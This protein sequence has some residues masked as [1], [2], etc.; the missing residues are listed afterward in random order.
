MIPNVTL[1]Q[2]PNSIC[3]SSLTN[4]SVSFN[5]TATASITNLVGAIG[6]YTFTWRNGQLVTD[7]VNNTSTN[8]NLVNL[9][10]GYYTTTAVQTST[11]CTSTP[12]SVEVQNTSLLPV[13]STTAIGS[14]NCAAP[15]ANGQ[16]LVTDVNGA[17][18]ALPFV[19]KWHTGV[20]TTTPIVGATGATL[21][22]RQG[23][24]GAFFTVLVTNQ[25][26]GCQNTATV[27]VPDNQSIP[28][29]TVSATDNENCSAPF[30]GTASV[31][32][33]IYKGL[34][35]GLGGYSF[36]W[37]HGATSSSAS[38][39]NVGTYELTVT[40]VDV[41][42]TS[43]PVQVDVNNNIY[44]PLINIAVTNQ[45]SCDVLNPNGGLS[46]S[47]SETIIGGA[48]TETAGYTY[49]WTNDGNPLALG[50]PP[51][52]NTSSINTLPGNLFY[53]L[54]V[55]RTAT[56]CPNTQSVFLPERILLP[57]LEIVA[58]DIV[59]CNTNGFVTARIFVDKNGDGDSNDAGDELTPI[60]I[61]GDYSISWF[62]GSSAIGTP[63]SETDR[64]I[65]EL[66]P[67]VSLP[68]GNY[69][70]I[71]TNV[72]TSCQ[73][74]DFTDVIN[75][76][77][78]LFDIAVTINNRP[79]SCA[80][81]DG[82]MTA[83]VDSGGGV[84][85]PFGNFTFQ[86]FKGNPTNGLDVPTPSFYTDPVVQFVQP[87][88][89]V[90]PAG[91]FVNP[92]P[93]FPAPQAPT[94]VNTGPSLFGQ[95]SGTY[96]V[97][98]KNNTT[99]CKEF[100]TVF[101]PFLQEPVIILARIK[102][103]ECSGD[104]GEIEVELNSP[105]PANQYQLQIYAS[106]NPVFSGPF[107]TLPAKP[108]IDP[109]SVLGNKFTGLASGIYSVVARENPLLIPTGCYSSP[110]L[111]QLIEALPPKVDI[112]GSTDNSTCAAAPLVGDGSLQI[113]V[114]TDSNDPFSASYPLPLPPTILQQG[115]APFVTYSVD[116]KDAGN[117]AVPG[118][119]TGSTLIDGDTENI[120]GL[121]G[122][123][124]SITVTSS[125]GCS[126]T[127]TFEIPN[128][129]R[130]ADLSGD[131][132]VL[133]ALAC[134]PSLETNASVIVN[135]LSIPGVTAADNLS[136]YEFKW[137][138]DVSLTTNILTANGDNTA[139]KGGEVLSNV[140][141]PLP[142]APV[143][144]GSY[145]VRASKI[146]SGTTGGLGCLTAP[147]KVDVDDQSVKPT[148]VL[149]ST[150]DT[151]C[152][153]VASFEGSVSV[154]VTDAGSIPTPDYSYIWTSTGVSVI[155]ND[156]L[157]NGSLI[158]NPGLSNGTY[159]LSFKNNT[160]GCVGTIQTTI[161]KS[162]TPIV[163]SDATPTDQFICNP[164]GSIT[165]G[166]NDILVNGIVDNNHNR[167][168]FTWSRGNA[169]NVVVGP[170]QSEDVLD[171]SNL[172]TI[173]AD[174]YFVKV[175]KRS[176]LIPGS[177]CESAPFRVDI[178]D[179]S[180]DPTIRLTS[181][182]NTSCDPLFFE[183][184]LQVQ[185]TNPG[186]AASPNYDYTWTSPVATPIVNA[187][188]VGNGSD[189]NDNIANL[190]DGTYTVIVENNASG[191]F[192]NAQT[193][194]SKQAT[195]IVIVNA[196]P[197]DQFICNPDGSIVVGANDILVA[198]AV[199]S[200]HSHFDFTWS[201]SNVAAIVVGPT[202]S[203]DVLDISNLPTIGA[204]SYFVKVKKRSG[205][206]PGSGCES[207]PF[208]V[209]ILD[210]SVDPTI[211]LTSSPNTS[212]DPLFFEGS[213]QV[214]VTNP[215]SAAS[216][217]YDYTWTSPVATPIVNAT[218]VG[219]GSDPNDNI[220]N[221]SDGTYTVIVEN[222]A[223]G[224]FGTAQTIISKQTTPI[225][226]V[227]VTVAPQLICNPDGSITVND[228]SV[229][230]IV[231]ADHT[232]FD[233][234][235]ARGNVATTVVG[236]SQSEDVLDILNLST[237]GADSY[238]VKVKRR[239]G[240]S[241]GSGCESTPFKVEILDESKDPEIAFTSTV[242]NSSCTPSSPNGF[243]QATASERIGPSGAY[244]FVW[245]FNG[246]AVPPVTTLG[247]ASPISELTNAGPGS[248]AVEATNSGTGCKFNQ[249][250]VL[251]T[252]QT[253]SLPNI[254]DIDQVNPTNCLPQGSVKVVSVTI[255]GTTVFTDP[256]DDLDTDYNY[257]W[258]KNS[259][260]S[261]LIA[262]EQNSLLANQLPGK[263]FV[264]VRN[265]ITD[266]LSAAVESVIDSANIVYPV[267]SI[268]QTAPQIICTVNL[269]SGALRALADGQNDTNPNYEFNWFS[270]LNLSGSSIASTSMIN[271]LIAGDYSLQ[272]HD[273]TTNC[274]ASAIFILPEDKIEFQPVL[275]LSINPLTECDT[276]DGAVFARGVL[277]PINTDP[278]KN[279]PFAYDYT[280]DMYI[281]NPPADLNN[282][283][284]PNMPPDP[285][286]PLFT[287]N[288]LQDN[289]P[290]GIY[291][292]RL[293]DTNTGCF[294]IDK[295][296]VDD[297]R[298]FPAPV[299]STI[300]PVTNCDPTNPN[301]VARVNVNG[302]FVG[303]EFNWYEGNN[304]AGIPVYTGAEFG[305]L[306]VSPQVYTIDAKNLDTGCTG[307]V[308]ANIASGTVAIPSPQ[309]VKISDVT[310][311]LF[312]NGALSVSV[313]GITKDYVFDW[314]DGT[315]ETPPSDF[316]GEL[317]D[318]LAVG[319][320][321]VTATSRITGCKSPLVNESITD[322]KEFPE[323]KFQIQNASCDLA[324]GFASVFF[325]SSVG[326]STIEWSRENQIVAFGPN[327]A[328][329]LSGLYM[330]RIVSEF[331]CDARE[332]IEILAD[333]RPR[334]GISRNGDSQNDYFHIDCIDQFESNN[335][336]VFNRV[337]TLVYEA[338]GYDNANIFFNG[339]S[340][341]GVSI[342]GTNVPDGTYFFIVDKR[343]GSKP[344]AGYL[345]IVK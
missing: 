320:Y 263:Y 146:I 327:L 126:T 127:K 226:I 210:K 190:S 14:T 314:Y 38:G 219:N 35:E 143:A 318:S 76:P 174:S 53:T 150:S 330:V 298:K 260:P 61:A 272:V 162:A 267:V 289:L 183:G 310:S 259:I 337:G 225:I 4:P 65:N 112:L 30:N 252:N 204:D 193:I 304:L 141:A 308:Q 211:R 88:L 96:S 251:Q 321:S 303:F 326:I 154:Q 181:S 73:T 110:V 159:S 317:Y 173:G 166:P 202:Q 66:S 290:N 121:R 249:V 101:L 224:C 185:V 158:N 64:I 48:A 11:G 23:G 50:G 319:V 75:G 108:N 164:D 107:A 287:E 255:G 19:F 243:I 329:A 54:T 312:N 196:T 316:I 37:T 131:V 156:P 307:S 186:S 297:L 199:D 258:F 275:A 191:C 31:N 68:A 256:P 47:M 201:R 340:N 207:A 84:P 99:G 32:S 163:I 142:V 16:A 9:N 248:Y 176:G 120:N 345:E 125:K 46:A 145:W 155:A 153:T 206:I 209:D 41:G 97:V 230:G 144:A 300:A 27:E 117:V 240:F 339:V 234:T 194:I 261:G 208:R 236:P 129:P 132:A 205:L 216:P 49:S 223:S 222:N 135:N 324:N 301:G 77:G 25:S 100:K 72:N 81:S 104:V 239:T 63:L 103:D 114:S 62:R 292:V 343:D 288:H 130:V 322:K 294:T 67:G 7:P 78:A 70:S 175:K 93:G 309:I 241:P 124:Y 344:F 335:V 42:C 242:P 179:K 128:A 115:A 139:T 92:H 197:L 167:F 45:T 160:S 90:D 221:L 262:G 342:S 24:V 306:K 233:F 55:E 271:S 285:N 10:G 325:T 246:G 116:V 244:N 184:S 98:V 245:T 5:G 134:V 189:P 235:W 192:G 332:D 33:I 177:G 119:P 161:E 280:A 265:V 86:W 106:A 279:Y 270:N 277:F 338:D 6:G 212:C 83:F 2:S 282:P 165:V 8:Q 188:S 299:V 253:L 266:C 138:T 58:T 51:V 229:G 220:A 85:A 136:D 94:S 283:E 227:N 36:A 195:P 109:A 302:T 28:L 52:G 250:F 13:I 203:E 1:A 87:A 137:F 148:A 122:E 133:P 214:Q 113:K 26:N 274:R 82:L 80:D 231:D 323:F 59:D 273:L 341:R 20:D 43:V 293:T 151:S 169:S 118:Y 71:A 213:L 281:G 238:F 111:V 228:I 89:D 200:D 15:L 172:P 333:I 237:I 180:V 315:T 328:D 152:E 264:R 182:P 44:I 268:Q 149:T 168:D 74:S 56:R 157:A 313:G 286:N 57:R 60:E 217:N 79:A 334:N 17:G 276:D 311:C 3:D 331:G 254:I 22:N 18:T 29:L 247:G 291:T 232:H 198:G 269:G 284:F 336:K 278:A 295:V 12:V 21:S 34:P 147:F 105:N 40:R 39:L 123:T 102:P 69:T 215:G 95:K 140:G 170:T 296:S 305:E 187:T 257:E 91:D 178:L 218:S 171:I